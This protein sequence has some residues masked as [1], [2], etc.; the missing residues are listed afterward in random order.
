MTS[1]ALIWRSATYHWRTNLAVVLGVATAVSVLSGALLVGDSVR[2]SLRDLAVGRLGRTEH[3]ISTTGFFRDALARDV[4]D[5]SPGVS[6]A[7]LVV[8]SGFVTHEASGRRAGGVT[9]YGVDQRFWTFHG[10]PDRSGVLLSPSLAMELG[11]A[12]ND[13]LL[14]RLQKPS[15]IP[16]ESLFGRKDEVARTIRLTASATLPSEQLG[17]FS[18]RPQQS[19]VRALFVPLSRLQRDLGVIDRVNTVLVSGASDES[20]A[21]TVRRSV[22]LD[23]LSATIAITNAP[24]VVVESSAG[25]VGDSLFTAATHAG[26]AAGLESIP[27]FTYLA[28]T[29]RKGDRAIPYSLVTATD[30]G[31]TG[32]APPARTGPSHPSDAIVLNEWAARE[33]QAVPGDEITLDYYLWDAAA[34]LTSHGATFRL[35]QIVPIAGFAADRRLAPEYPGITAANSLADWDP[36]FPVD[37]SRVQPRDEAYWKDY[38]T[39]PKAFIDFERGRQLW[40]NRYGAATSVRFPLAAGADAASVASRLREA[41]AALLQPQASGLTI[42]AARR[43]ALAASEGATDF[44]AYFT[45]FSFFIVASALLLSVLF[46]RLGIEQRLRQ[47]GILRASGFTM[48]QLR[49][50]LLVEA[51]ALAMLGSAIGT[52]GA[53]GYGKLMVHGLRTWWVGAVGTTHLTLHLSVLSLLIGGL[54]GIATAVICVTISLRAVA[55]LSPRTL[56]QAQAIDSERAIAAPT[57]RLTIVKWAC[58]IAALGML[59]A[60]FTGNGDSAGLFFGAAA[61]LLVAAMCQ[62]SAAL[63]GRE[64]TPITER[65]GRALWRLG[66]RSAAYRPARSVLSAALIAAAAFIIVSVDAFRRGSAFSTEVHSGTGGF[67]LLADSEVPLLATPNDPAGREALVVNAPDF[68]RIRFTRF[69]LRPGQD[70]SCLNLYRPTTPTIIAPEAGFIEQGRF[71]FAASMAATDAER[72][73][74]WLLLRRQSTDTIPVIADATSLEYALHASV[75]DTFAMDVGAEKPIVLQFVGALSDSV[76]QGQLVVSEEHFTKLF[77]SIQGYRFFLVDDPAA[78]NQA[79]ADRLA[80]ILERELAPFGLDAVTTAER[81]EAFHRVENTYLSTFQALGGLGLLLGTI[82]LSAIM[83][84]NVLERRRELALLRAVGYGPR[85]V[86]TV[87]VAEAALLVGVGLVAGAACAVLAVAPAWFS[88]GGSRPGI[89]LLILLLSVAVAGLISSLIAARAALRGRLLESLAVE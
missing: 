55:R 57:K 24:A 30:L 45:Y 8:A 35:T 88:R 28:N 48:A 84:R 83:F 19:E 37:L 53:I 66:F 47:I 61:A 3:V 41:M 27:V 59:L 65:G 7:P 1:K 81:L 87:I 12:A 78:V 76:L 36:P 63:R 16:V 2:G 38:R 23:D 86:S 82:G 34:G 51:L 14:L 85:H 74:P 18:I 4:H 20:L 21:A 46:F 44:G 73:N 64:S 89:G 49:R 22:T 10:L 75:G 80:G 56:L 40:A 33:L 17:D 26:S 50:L 70:A 67:A 42:A 71:A 32:F 77:P 69:R 62:L 43:D 68:S 52:I 58:A 5:A 11:A 60:G 39:T 15:A 13:T 6:T 54:A 25:I 29:I 9:V 72:A 31:L 79:A